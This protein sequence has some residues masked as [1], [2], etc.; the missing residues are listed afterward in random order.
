MNFVFTNVMRPVSAGQKYAINTEIYSNLSQQ[1]VSLTGG[2]THAMQPSRLQGC[3]SASVCHSR[4]GATSILIPL[5]PL[6]RSLDPREGPSVAPSF[7]GENP[8][9]IAAFLSPLQSPTQPPSP[10]T[11]GTKQPRPKTIQDGSEFRM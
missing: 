4:V 6:F 2:N 10:G 9:S 11:K 3:L 7:L 5:S 1:S 8:Q